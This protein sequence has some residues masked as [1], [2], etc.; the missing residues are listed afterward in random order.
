MKARGFTLVEL[1]IAIAISGIVMVFAS[2]FIMAPVDAYQAHSRR[3]VLVADA[4]AAWPLM[5]T[6]LRAALPNSL[7]ARRNGNIVVLEMLRVVDVARYKTPASATTITTAGV[8][9][10]ITLP[11]DSNSHY[12]FVNNGASP[13]VSPYASAALMTPAGSRIRIAAGGAG[14]HVVTLD[15]APAFPDSPKHRIYLLSGPVTYLC[16]EGQGT[17]TRYSNYGIAAAQTAR[18]TAAELNGAGATSALVAQGLTTCNFAASPLDAL[19]SQTAAVR[20]TTTR[21]GDSVTL[22]HSSRAEYLP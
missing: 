14:E 15:A 1:V 13:G 10:G 3:A 2:M 17:L 12:L 11:F 22:L 21:S 16:D 8:F 19:Q 20:L 5:E 4:S 18:D 7:R 9:R 6:D